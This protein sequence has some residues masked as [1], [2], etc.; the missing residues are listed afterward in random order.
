MFSPVL[1]DGRRYS[2]VLAHRAQRNSARI[3]YN[4][5]YYTLSMPQPCVHF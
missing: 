3:S 2:T 4:F 1:F 5:T